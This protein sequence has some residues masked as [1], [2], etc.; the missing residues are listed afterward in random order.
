MGA[1]ALAALLAWIG[2]RAW[3]ECGRIIP[4]LSPF[5]SVCSAIALRSVG[6]FFLLGLP[7]LILAFFRGR[8]FCRCLC[9]TGTVAW[10]AGGLWPGRR[11]PAL[12]RVYFGRW[13]AAFALGGAIAGLPWCFWLDPLAMWNGFFSACWPGRISGAG[14]WFGAGLLLVALSGFFVPH[15]W[16]ER[17]CPLG[18]CQNELGAL[19]VWA[20]RRL[21]LTPG[22]AVEPE[23]GGLCRR[24]FL[25]IGAAVGAI[26]ALGGRGRTSIAAVRPP[27]AAPGDGFLGL[28][29]RCGAC[30]RACPH[31]IIEPDLG[32][33]GFSALL[34][35]RLRYDKGYCSEWCVECT[36]VCPTGAIR[37]L[38]LEAKKR[39]ALGL[40]VVNRDTCLAWSQGRYCMICDE[41]CPYDAIVAT[42][43]NGINC[44]TVDEKVCA[45][46]GA[47]ESQCPVSP[48]KAILVRGH[49]VQQQVLPREADA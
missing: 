33:S 27:G 36:K 30:F 25:A 13:L 47:C 3:V 34:A 15:L 32:E 28:C 16:C 24:G 44:P 10:L 6:P 19:G 29:S 49:A 48:R 35:P 11:T 46:C 45:G 12:P 23:G 22:R 4:G 31:G 39:T 38:S 7:L 5:L 20:R 40:A 18:A 9:P 14:K 2:P 21:G 17:L 8:W 42:Q 1:L 37:G 41:Y 26:L 43:V